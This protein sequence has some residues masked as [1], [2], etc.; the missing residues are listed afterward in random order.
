MLQDATEKNTNFWKRQF[1]PDVT[2]KQFI[3]DIVFGIFA[4][5]LC[6]IFDPFVFRYNSFLGSPLVEYRVFAYLGIILGTITLT[7]WL[8]FNHHIGL[9]WK[10]FFAGILLFG[11]IFASIGGIVLLPFSLLGLL[12]YGIGLLGFIPF[13]TGFVFL[14]NGVRAIRYQKQVSSSTEKTQY[15][16]TLILGLSMIIAI[17]S[18][19]QWQTSQIVLQGIQSILSGNIADSEKGVQ[20]LKGAFWCDN[21]CY[22]KLVDA[23]MKE[24]DESRRTILAKAYQEIT[25]R[26]IESVIQ[27]MFID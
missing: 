12:A 5:L 14:R 16:T 2:T 15:W 8:T 7:C 9:K 20:S 17:P 10:G 23:Y 4:P 19:S 1:S 22:E 18:Y 27:E 11:A 6:L 13:I 21:A 24:K 3:F 26:N 25:G